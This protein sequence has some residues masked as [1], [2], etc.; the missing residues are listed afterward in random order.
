MV[1]HPFDHAALADAAIAA[2]AVV[3]HVETRRFQCLDD[4]LT[5]RDADDLSASI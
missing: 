3:E 4:G 1:G 5:G 2:L